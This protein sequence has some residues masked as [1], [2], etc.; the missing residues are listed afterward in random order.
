MHPPDYL[1]N[2]LIS[3]QLLIPFVD[4]QPLNTSDGNFS[5]VYRA[6]CPTR[7]IPVALKFMLPD[8]DQSE[9][10]RGLAFDREAKLLVM[11]SGLPNVTQMIHD[12]ERLTISLQLAGTPPV[13]ITMSYRYFGLAYYPETL[14]GLLDSRSRPFSDVLKVFR[15]I[16]KGMQQIHRISICHRDLAPANCFVDGTTGLLGDFGCARRQSQEDSIGI[17]EKYRF[18]FWG[19]TRYV[20]PEIFLGLSDFHDFLRADFY[21]LGAI[22]FEICTGQILSD[23]VRPALSQLMHANDLL[24]KTSSSHSRQLS[25]LIVASIQTSGQ[26]PQIGNQPPIPND[27]TRVHMQGLFRKLCAFDP[28]QRLMDFDEIFR[29][30]DKGIRSASKT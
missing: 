29:R 4:I 26:L 30:V 1:T 16:S 10:R 6:R 25:E 28:Q 21:S 12:L 2:L 14:K 20:A 24:S 11:L 5:Y 22:L 8:L 27:E 13:P 19:Q 3:R 18:D 9:P 15:D 17:G 7:N 23:V